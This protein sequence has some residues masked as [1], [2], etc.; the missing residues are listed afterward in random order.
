MDQNKLFVVISVSLA[1]ALIGFAVFS[2]K[3]NEGNETVPANNV[4][5]VDGKQIVEITAK[6]GYLP[7]RSQAQA[8]LPTILKFNTK[9]TL[10]CSS[11]VLISKLNIQQNLPVSGIT[12]ID[13]GTQKTGTLQGSCGMG[14]FPFE[15]VFS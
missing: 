15:I 9:G 13:I 4:S 3:K 1:L 5:I 14:M 8:G 12:D 6:G 11:A 10:D 7:R 2:T